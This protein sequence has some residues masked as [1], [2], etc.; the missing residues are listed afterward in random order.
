MVEPAELGN[1]RHHRWQRTVRAIRMGRRNIYRG[2]DHC[3]G[4]AFNSVEAAEASTVTHTK[5][6]LTIVVVVLL[7]AIF[8]W[9]LSRTDTAAP[10]TESVTGNDAPNFDPISLLSAWAN[11]IK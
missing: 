1:F 6:A 5:I 10:G 3:L 8:L 4:C 7:V 2:R 9:W 11:A